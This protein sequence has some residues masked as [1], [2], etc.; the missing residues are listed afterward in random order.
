MSTFVGWPNGEKLTKV[1]AGH[2]KSTQVCRQ[3][4]HNFN[5]LVENLRPLASPFSQGFRPHREFE[6]STPTPG[7]FSIVA[8]VK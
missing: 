1:N 6:F 5:T 4:E 7:A 3:T 8:G 2:S